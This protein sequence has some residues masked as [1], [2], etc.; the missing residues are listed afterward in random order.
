[1][2]GEK[3]LKRVADRPATLRVSGGSES[4]RSILGAGSFVYSVLSSG[5]AGADCIVQ[6][7][8]GLIRGVMLGAGTFR[9][10]VQL[11]GEVPEGD[12]QLL[13]RVAG[14]SAVV[15]G[16]REK[17]ALVFDGVAEGTWKLKIVPENI[18]AV[19]IG[20]APEISPTATATAP[21][22]G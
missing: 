14:L 10:S 13:H 1:M 19:R 3:R 5:V 9:V 22:E 8:S 15:T 6:D 20:A 18:V 21:S 7:S 4:W 17:T 16:R 12:Q 2:R 11:R